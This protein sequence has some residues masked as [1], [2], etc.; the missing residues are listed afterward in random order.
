M[1]VPLKLTTNG[2]INGCRDRETLLERLLGAAIEHG[3]WIMFRR[4]M[5]WDA[6]NIVRDQRPTIP[7]EAIVAEYVVQKHVPN[8][9]PETGVVIVLNRVPVLQSP[10]V[11]EWD[12]SDAPPPFPAEEPA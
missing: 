4:E 3:P 8:C 6:H 7:R 5:S 2:R 1:T 10:P 9:L 11:A 12:E